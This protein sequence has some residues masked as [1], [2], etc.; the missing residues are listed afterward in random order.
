MS[1][2]ALA[3]GVKEVGGE[4]PCTGNVVVLYASAKSD[5]VGLPGGTGNPV[6][7]TCSPAASLKIARPLVGSC[8][9]MSRQSGRGCLCPADMLI[10]ISRKNQEFLEYRSALEYSRV[11][12]IAKSIPGAFHTYIT[13]SMRQMIA[14]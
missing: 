11:R 14:N 13:C 2:L 9:V 12:N 6:N 7:D 10:L 4:S 1:R 8:V 3:S 5:V